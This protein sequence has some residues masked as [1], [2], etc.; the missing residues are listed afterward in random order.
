M[1]V[2]DGSIKSSEELR[3]LF[4]RLSPEVAA[5]AKEQ[6]FEIDNQPDQNCQACDGN[7]F[8]GYFPNAKVIPCPCVFAQHDSWARAVVKQR[9]LGRSLP[10]RGLNVLRGE[11]VG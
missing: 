6:W 9:D 11:K 10:D 4:E 7:G 1:N 3:K 2:N 5:Q 8:I